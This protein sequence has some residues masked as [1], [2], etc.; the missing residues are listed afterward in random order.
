VKVGDRVRDPNGRLGEVLYLGRA[1]WGEGRQWRR[2]PYAVVELESGLRRSFRVE[3]LT[4]ENEQL[5]IEQG[6]QEEAS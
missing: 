4:V 2:F 1:N 5:G 3:Q 6:E